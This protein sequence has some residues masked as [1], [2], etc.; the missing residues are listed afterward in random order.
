VCVCV[1]VT[2]ELSYTVF[3]Y[4]GVPHLEAAADTQDGVELPGHKHRILVLSFI[5]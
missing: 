2:H 4:L 5:Y 3:A 1:C